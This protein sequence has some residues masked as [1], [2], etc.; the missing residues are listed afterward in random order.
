MQK[1]FATCYLPPAGVKSQRKRFLT[2]KILEK[3]SKILFL[4]AFYVNVMSFDMIYPPPPVEQCRICQF[5][6][7]FCQI[8][9][10]FSVF[11]IKG[12]RYS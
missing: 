8:F 2:Q 5:L 11:W 10:F 9:I 12:C 7:F 1:R 6:C 3:Q 4:D